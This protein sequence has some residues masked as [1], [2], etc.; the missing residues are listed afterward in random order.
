MDLFAST[1]NAQ[2]ERFVSEKENAFSFDC[3]I[4]VTE[5]PVWIYPPMSLLEK[6][7]TKLALY[8]AMGVVIYL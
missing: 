7:L 6:A 5:N 8:K 1:Q 3:E 2:E 4:L